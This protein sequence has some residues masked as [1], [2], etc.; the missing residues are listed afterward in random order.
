MPKTRTAL[1]AA[2]G[3]LISA[4]QREWSDEAGKPEAVL[5]EQVLHASHDLL[6]AAKTGSIVTVIGSASIADFLGRQWVE[7]H[8]R[9]W[10]HIQALV[11]H[12]ETIQ[13]RTTNSL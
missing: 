6:Q 12:S 5:S 2:A 10:P 9:V 7:S 3:Q 8:S 4:I 13:G 1:E 11:D